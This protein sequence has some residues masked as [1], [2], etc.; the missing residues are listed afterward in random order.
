MS[1]TTQSYEEWHSNGDVFCPTSQ[2]LIPCVST[3]A[4]DKAPEEESDSAK[5]EEEDAFVNMFVHDVDPALRT[6][7]KGHVSAHQPE[8]GH[9]LTAAP[10]SVSL[11]YLNN[12]TR[13]QNDTSGEM[14]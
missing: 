5:K 13:G 14:D 6:T 12:A 8:E 1:L 7:S 9:T 10:P 2:L 4:K 3:D 11:H